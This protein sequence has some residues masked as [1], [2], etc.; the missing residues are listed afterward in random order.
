MELRKQVFVFL[1][2]CMTCM[3]G[4]AQTVIV[5]PDDVWMKENGFV[6]EKDVD[7]AKMLSFRYADALL[8]HREM[9][10]ALSCAQELLKDNGAKVV[11]NEMIIK[12]PGT[13]ESLSSLMEQQRPD[14]LVYLDY[15]VKENRKPFKSLFC[16]LKAFDAYTYDLIGSMN[17]SENHMMDPLQTALK[18]LLT[19]ESHGFMDEI[20]HY[21]ADLNMNGRK[22]NVVF[23]AADGS[24]V[25]FQNDDID[26][27]VLKDYLMNW[28]KEHSVKGALQLGRQ[29]STICEFRGVRI[30]FFDAEGNRTD[31][32]MWGSNAMKELREDSG[33]K[34]KRADNT[35][36][37]SVNFIIGAE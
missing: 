34:I 11:S 15:S 2:V 23:S 4:I 28:L 33:L 22:I 7:G 20:L 10:E 13:N 21:A 36:L 31:Y 25:D 24:G 29:K 12:G 3:E 35:S 6:E 8:N 17:K 9:S 26:G 37:G 18:E 1:L 16:S 27:Q 19:F 32:E 30:P 5:I 14:F